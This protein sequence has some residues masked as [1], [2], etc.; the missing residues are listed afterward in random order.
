[1][2][3]GVQLASLLHANPISIPRARDRRVSSHGTGESG[4]REQN[5]WRYGEDM[6]KMSA[7]Q[8]FELLWMGRPYVE[9]YPSK[10]I[11]GE[12]CYKNIQ[13]SSQR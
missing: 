2:A 1:M 10:D 9:M 4:Q 12:Q 5:V 11:T 13:Y 8:D 7:S 6:G 3:P